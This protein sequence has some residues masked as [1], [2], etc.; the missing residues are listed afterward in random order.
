VLAKKNTKKH[1]YNQQIIIIFLKSV[2][3][4][5][6]KRATSHLFNGIFF[7]LYHHHQLTG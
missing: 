4:V 5:Y 6:K 2:V 1:K 3:K 7:S